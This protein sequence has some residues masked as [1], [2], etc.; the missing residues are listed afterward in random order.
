MPT[1]TYPDVPKDEVGEMVQT[2][3]DAGAKRVTVTPNANG[4]TCTVV[5]ES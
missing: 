4:T 2:Q 3:I 5:V 1:Q